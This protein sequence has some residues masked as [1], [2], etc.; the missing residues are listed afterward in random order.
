MDSID[1]AVID[2]L[3]LA[4]RLAILPKFVSGQR[5]MVE[6][7]SPGEEV[8]AADRESE[9]ILAEALT[10]LIPGARIIGEEA[11]GAD[12][13]LLS[14][15]GRGTCWI[16]DPLDGT[17]NF[18]RGTGPFGIMVALIDNGEPVGGWILDPLRDR[19]MWARSGS[20]AWANGKPLRA[21]AILH[22]R[23]AVAVT[24]L[25]ADPMVR[26]HLVSVL[27]RDCDVSQ[28]PRCA[29]EQYPC[30]A[31]GECDATIFTRTLPWDHAAGAILLAEAG[32]QAR[33]LGGGRYHCE[34]GQGGLI[35]AT[36]EAT[37]EVVAEL[38][39]TSRIALAGAAVAN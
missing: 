12:P 14:G 31:L 7:K 2:A 36:N 21:P 1:A 20:G 32:G 39:E 24:S 6:L 9:A 16:I 8:T 22:P 13:G 38:V 3:R 4:A 27:T 28:S 18:A 17:A 5:V 34:D 25:F 10:H 15:L 26:D 37:W 35:V 29:A 30:V 11:A 19:V 33:R 23:P